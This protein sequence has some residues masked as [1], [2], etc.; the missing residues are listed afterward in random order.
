[1]SYKSL[2]LMALI[3]FTACNSFGPKEVELI[4][5]VENLDNNYALLI[6]KGITDTIWL[7]KDGSFNTK[8]LLDAPTYYTLRT[9]RTRNTIFLAPGDI[10]K[11]RVDISNPTNDPVVE[12]KYAKA[13]SLIWGNNNT[14]ND[15]SK[16][17]RSLYG[18]PLDRFN[19]KLDS[20]KTAINQTIENSGVTNKAF[21]SLEKAR[22]NYQLLSIKYNYPDY[23]SRISGEKFTPDSNYYAFV[24]DVNFDNIKHFSLN[25]YTG[26]VYNHI[27]SVYWTEME[28]DE[29]KGKSQFERSLILFEMIDS[30]VPN[31]AI[32]DYFKCTSTLETVKWE[33]LEI[34]KNV[35]EYFTANAKTQ[36]YID[37]INQAFAK[38]MLLAPGQTAP[39]FT[40]TGIDGKT[41]SLSDFKGQLVYIDFWATWCGPCRRQIPF[42]AKLKSAYKGKPI[43]FVAISIDDN[44]DAWVKMV[45]EDKLDGIQ[46]YADRAWLSDAAQQ[47]QV[48]AIPTFVLI[49][50]NGKIIEYPATPPSDEA[51]P[52]LL[53]KHLKLL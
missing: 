1:M 53:D 48:F 25:E 16:D 35:S 15:L 17:F 29:Y 38:R 13:N 43:A 6:S 52:L 37:I 45:T 7:N 5:Q 26:L 42:M 9:G 49:D 47:Y 28:K 22:M 4:G 51:T 44:K 32:R 18:L 27:Q 8:F 31:Q 41:Y 23:Y 12:G 34:A 2:A 10:L 21:V 46:L 24:K 50:G 11:V 39:N 36:A 3:A 30:L 19:G 40:L 14:I 33:S 20:V